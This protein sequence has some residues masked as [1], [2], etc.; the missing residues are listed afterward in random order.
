[1]KK[2]V[3][4][5]TVATMSLLLSACNKETPKSH[6]HVW[7]EVTYTWAEDYLSC[8]AERVCTLDESHIE[9]ETNNSTYTVLTEPTFAEDGIGRYTGEFINEAFETQTHD[10]V[11]PQLVNDGSVPVL[12]EDG[13]TVTYGIFP[14]TRISDS[15]FVFELETNADW[16]D[17]GWYEYDGDYYAKVYSN[18]YATDYYFDNGDLIEK[19]KNYWFKYEPI[20]WNVL[21]N[22][23]GECLLVSET[24]LEATYYSYS[25][26]NNYM[27]SSIRDHLNDEFL[28]RAFV[29]GDDNLLTT[30]VDNSAASTASASNPYACD[31]TEDKVFLLS[32]KDYITS[33]YGFSTSDSNSSTRYCKTTDYSR[34]CGACISTSSS[35]LN[36]GLYWTRSPNS[37]NQRYAMHVRTDGTIH[38]DNNT[39]Y[40][41]LCTRPAIT[42]TLN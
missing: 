20:T 37:G 36:N 39:N 23:D 18:P 29:L 16:L 14:Q 30:T 32:Y 42:I 35:T 41:Y 11:I 24:L 13:K 21:S 12:S 26:N 38:Y 8:T 2:K 17:S 25:N 4:L 9:T 3:L 22:D 40:K 10:V 31:N 34:A 28:T 19:N 7:G 5:L 6:Q 33:D 27:N 1:M 15:D